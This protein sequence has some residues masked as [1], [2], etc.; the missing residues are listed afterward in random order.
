[1]G[2]PCAG[3]KF[4]WHKDSPISPTI[5]EMRKWMNDIRGAVLSASFG[6]ENELVLLA[7]ADEFGTNDRGS[8]GVE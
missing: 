7:L 6:I 1:M 3:G 4:A 2:T 5:W 8:V